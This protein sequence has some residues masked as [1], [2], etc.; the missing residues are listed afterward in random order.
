MALAPFLSLSVEAFQA[1]LAPS[2]GC[3]FCVAS[4]AAA[5]GAELCCVSILSHISVKM[6]RNRDHDRSGMVM[7]VRKLLFT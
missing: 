3:S 7:A 6:S 5:D 2:D 1:F 4:P